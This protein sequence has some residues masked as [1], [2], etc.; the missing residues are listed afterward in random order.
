M[1]IEKKTLKNIFLGVAACII[2][3]WLLHSTESVN[4]FFSTIYGIISPFLLGAGLAFVFNVPMRAIEKRLGGLK[5]I[6]AR[7][8]VAIVLTMLLVLLVLALVFY[9]LIP[10]LIETTQS[11]IP[12]MKAFF[13]HLETNL[14]AF[15]SANPQIK[16]WILNNTDIENLNWAGI[17]EKSLSV[18]GN[19]LSSIL[20]GMFAAIGSI[21]GALVNIVIAI[22]F[23]IYCLCQKETLAR[24]GKKLLYAFLPGNFADNFVRVVRLTNSTFSNFLSGQCVEVCILGA[25]FAICMAIFKMPYIPLVSVLIAVSAFIP[26]VGAFFGCICGAFLILVANPVQAIGFVIMFLVIQ[27][28]ENNVIYPRVVGTSIGLS[29]MWVLVAVAVG[30]ELFGVA[31]MFIMIPVAA[32]IHTLLSEI[33]DNKLREKGIDPGRFSTVPQP[34]GEKAKRSSKRAKKETPDTE[35]LSK[36]DGSM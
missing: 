23:A 9:L 7:R 12:K 8:V 24:Q 11:L 13:T 10:Q 22:V 36:E 14:F 35:N 25:M 31:G 34:T 32:V 3:Y 16:E 15:L 6:T 5:S 17:V 20:T 21:T 26:V 29:G 28:I 33:T 18:L 30:G 19:S 4:G 2:L 1:H 27:Q